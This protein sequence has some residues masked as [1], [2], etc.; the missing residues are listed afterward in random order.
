ML[1]PDASCFPFRLAPKGHKDDAAHQQEGTVDLPLKANLSAAVRKYL[2]TLEIDDPDTDADLAALIWFHSLAI[3]YSP[4]YLDEN[5]DGIRSD[6]PRIP[7]PATKT[8]LLESAKLGHLVAELLDPKSQVT[9]L[10][11]GNDMEPLFFLTGVVERV[12][13]GQLNPNSGDLDLTAGWGHAG[14]DGVTMPAKG[15]IR[16]RPFSTEEKAAIVSAAESRGIS[17]EKAIAL[18]GPDTRDVYLNEHAF[19]KNIP[20]SAWEFYIGGYQSSRNG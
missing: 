11:G 19:W 20:A 6:W 7:L 8:L 18:V 16:E 17:A 5:A 3:G 2:S 12:G 4:S 9:G 13:G 14:K 1:S 10:T 15:T